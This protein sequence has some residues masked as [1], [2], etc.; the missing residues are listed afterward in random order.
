MYLIWIFVALN[1]WTNN[2]TSLFLSILTEIYFLF[3]IFYLLCW[4]VL[5]LQHLVNQK[6]WWN[7][8]TLNALLC[9]FA[10]VSPS[11]WVKELQMTFVFLRT[12][13]NHVFLLT[14]CWCTGNKRLLYLQICPWSRSWAPRYENGHKY[15]TSFMWYVNPPVSPLRFVLVHLT[16][17]FSSTQS[18]PRCVCSTKTNPIH[19]VL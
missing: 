5:W 8:V 15:G 1:K 7:F 17:R 18:F 2:E 3:E 6:Y 16:V 11:L 14:F 10:N 4:I 19:S 12:W 13:L 9:N